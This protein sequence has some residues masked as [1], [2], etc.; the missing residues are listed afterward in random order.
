MPRAPDGLVALASTRPCPTAS[1]VCANF[2][3]LAC[4]A[5]PVPSSILGCLHERRGGF[6]FPQ[7]PC[8]LHVSVSEHDACSFLAS[9]KHRHGL[10]ACSPAGPSP[11]HFSTHTT[12]FASHQIPLPACCTASQ[13]L[14]TTSSVASLGRLQ[15]AKQI[16]TVFTSG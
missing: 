4:L 1:P 11:S 16:A 7:P 12:C 14:T 2:V 3:C 9:F 10:A 13:A 6:F 5:C 8:P 15:N